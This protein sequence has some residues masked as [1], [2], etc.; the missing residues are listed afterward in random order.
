M[1]VGSLLQSRFYGQY[2]RGSQSYTR[3]QGQAIE[4]LKKNPA[5]TIL[6]YTQLPIREEKTKKVC[7]WCCSSGSIT[8]RVW[9]DR[10]G[11]VPGETIYFNAEVDNASGKVMDGSKVQLVEVFLEKLK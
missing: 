8:G 2:N 4:N 9:I 11:Y 3:S 5:K 7:C 10:A 6:F 1:E